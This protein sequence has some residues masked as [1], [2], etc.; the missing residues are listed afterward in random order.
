MIEITNAQVQAT[1]TALK[2]ADALLDG[3]TVK[4]FQN[5]IVPGP[6]SVLGDFTVADFT[7]Y[8]TSAAL[9]WAGPVLK[10]DGTPE[11]VAQRLMFTCTNATTP[12][13]IYGYYLLDSEGG[14][15]GAERFEAP[16]QVSLVGD[17]VM[18]VP[19]ISIEYSNSASEVS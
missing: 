12:N 4:L 19:R 18:F 14:L 5:D 1:L 9:V 15:L 10:D 16:Q 8:A 7:G 2:E 3:V 11:L 17:T 13:T 6:D